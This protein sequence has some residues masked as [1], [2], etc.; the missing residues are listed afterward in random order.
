M[1]EEILFSRI[2][3]DDHPRD[4]QRGELTGARNLIPLE[5]VGGSPRRSPLKGFEKVNKNLPTGT[6]TCIGTFEDQKENRI[7]YFLWNSGNNHSIW[8]YS[9]KEHK[10][11]LE[12]SGLNFRKETRVDGIGV[13]GNLVAWT[14]GENEPRIIDLAKDY[15]ELTMSEGLISLLRPPPLYPATVEKKYDSSESINYISTSTYQFAY[16][17][18]YDNNEVSVLSR[19]SDAVYPSDEENSLNSTED[20]YVEVK[21]SVPE[22]IEPVVKFVQIYYRKGNEDQWIRYTSEPFTKLTTTTSLHTGHK[23]Y[24]SKFYNNEAQV[25]LSNEESGIMQ[26][27]LPR[28]ANGLTAFEN[29]VFIT[30]D[31]VNRDKSDVRV[32]TYVNSETRPADNT[33]NLY[34]KHKGQFEVGVVYSDGKGRVEFV[35]NTA[36][37]NIPD[38]NVTGYDD[39]TTTGYRIVAQAEGRPPEWA[40]DYQFVISENKYHQVYMQCPVRVMFHQGEA[41]ETIP[42]GYYS[43]GTE[44]YLKAKPVYSPNLH[45]QLPNNVSFIPDANDYFIRPIEDIG[46]DLGIA[47]VNEVFGDRIQVKSFTNNPNNT[48]TGSVPSRP[49]RANIP[50]GPTVELPTIFLAEIFSINKR[51][52]SLF[53]EYGKVHKIINP[54][55]PNRTHA[56]SDPELGIPDNGRHVLYGDTHKFEQ[57]FYYNIAEGQDSAGDYQQSFEYKDGGGFT[58]QTTQTDEEALKTEIETPSK[59]LEEYNNSRLVVKFNLLVGEDFGF[60]GDLAEALDPGA[61]SSILGAGQNNNN[62]T[63]Q[64]FG[65]RYPR[66]GVGNIPL[67]LNYGRGKVLDYSVAGNSYGRPN[68]TNDFSKEQDQNNIIG[69]SRIFSDNSDINGI[70]R[71]DFI[72]QYTLPR[73]RGEIIKLQPAKN[74]LLAIHKRNCTSL[75]VN[76]G[77]VKTGN[78][79]QFLSKTTD[80]IG[81]D[82]WLR[83]GLGTEHPG[84]VVEKDGMIFFW[85]INSSELVRYDGN[86]LTP[87]A[88]MYKFKKQ[89]RELTEKYLPYKDLLVVTAGFHPRHKIYYLTIQDTEIPT[90]EPDAT[91]TL[92][93]ITIGFSEIFNSFLGEFD[94]KPDAY[95]TFGDDLVSFKNGELYIHD[96]TTNYNDFYGTQYNSE[97]SFI[98]NAEQ[99]QKKILENISIK[100]SDIWKVD[101]VTSPDGQVSSLSEDEFEEKEG[102]YYADFKR[103]ENT[104]PELLQAGQTA[105]LSGNVLKD[106]YFEITISNDVGDKANVEFATIGYLIQTGHLIG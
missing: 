24:I 96:K 98:F 3:T 6:N 16:R 65:P 55:L 64:Y 67:S 103:D 27:V 80:I 59:F 105:L 10:K 56:Q 43:Y 101:K 20:N 13:V 40:T 89:M 102:E 38:T 54:G 49:V 11:I 69:Y 94:F 51:K 71:F 44:V 28:R 17:F 90:D 62:P 91:E 81:D 47:K 66:N 48:W 30:N 85:D 68:I 42:S 52:D 61:I 45:L 5:G 12:W 97:L 99:Q 32:T 76:E 25:A 78:G 18:V 7:V 70:N 77:F 74:V 1:I 57:V 73:D 37:I 92:P 2:N 100:S 84:S 31:V 86:G 88:T 63:P 53:Y 104:A 9:N 22:V 46:F 8:V 36:I 75:Y 33:T 34:W 106:E 79:E 58:G 19:Y 26:E 35:E 15:S 93:G 83:Y 72:S 82:N 95:A 87:L 29:R 60:A 21:V 14:D 50:T 23:T 41:P 39:I 4:L